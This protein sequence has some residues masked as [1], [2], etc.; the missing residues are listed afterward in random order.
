MIVAINGKKR[1]SL[2]FPPISSRKKWNMPK[3]A[4]KRVTPMNK[5]IIVSAEWIQRLVAKLINTSS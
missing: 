3:K 1:R 4:G 2:L 5:L